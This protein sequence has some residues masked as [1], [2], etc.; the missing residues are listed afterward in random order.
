[1]TCTTCAGL[2]TP[3]HAGWLQGGA[4][5]GPPRPPSP[6]APGPRPRKG[7]TRATA[8]S[9]TPPMSGQPRVTQ[10]TSL[11]Q[12]RNPEPAPCLRYTRPRA[13]S[14]GRP[15]GDRGSGASAETEAVRNTER[16]G[17]RPLH[18]PRPF[19]R[20]SP[21]WGPLGPGERRKRPGQTQEARAPE[22]ALRPETSGSGSPSPS[23]AS[24]RRS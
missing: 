5:A 13:L 23:L 1:M 2:G 10:C 19:L 21:R 17:H 24:Q 8:L 16:L 20:G 18:A 11:S 12:V 6:W 9:T 15:V 14:E 3:A 22:A 7:P 4:T